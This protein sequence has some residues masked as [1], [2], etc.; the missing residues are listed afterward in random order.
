MFCGERRKLGCNHRQRR[1]IHSNHRTKLFSMKKQ[2]MGENKCTN[3][4]QSGRKGCLRTTSQ[5]RLRLA[6][7]P[8][9]GA[10]GESVMAVLNEQSFLQ[11]GT[12]GLRCFDSRLLAQRLLLERYPAVA[13]NESRARRFAPNWAQAD[14]RAGPACQGLPYQGSWHREAMTERFISNASHSKGSC[15]RSR[16]RGFH[17][18]C[19]SPWMMYL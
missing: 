13:A 1:K 18:T 10:T 14:S 4:G 6:S 5:S 16:L 15:L 9:R 7:S 11:S 12:T 2:S 19:P 3:V 17:R 8:G